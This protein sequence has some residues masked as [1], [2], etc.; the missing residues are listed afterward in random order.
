MLQVV[1]VKIIHLD[2]N[3]ML[4]TLTSLNFGVNQILTQNILFCTRHK[5]N[6]SRLPG[7]SVWITLIEELHFGR[8]HVSVS[9][10]AEQHI[11]LKDFLM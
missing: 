2:Q 7:T 11:F 8:E 9:N 4:E 3:G 5:V 1:L 6:S 10:T